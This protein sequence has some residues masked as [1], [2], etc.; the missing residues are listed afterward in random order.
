MDRFGGGLMNET[1]QLPSPVKKR[2]NNRMET[3][4]SVRHAVRNILE[5]TPAFQEASP[6]LKKDIAE[7]M[8][9]VSM[10][11]ADMIDED[12]QLTNEIKRRQQ[13]MAYSLAAG[14]ILGMQATRASGRT[15]QDI[16]EGIDFPG[17]VTD[18][19]NGVFRAIS[20]SN[21]QQLQS[22]GDL[23]TNVTASSSSFASRNITVSDA[24][25]WA[26]QNFHFLEP[27]EEDG[28]PSLQVKKDTD[29]SE[30]TNLLKEA[31][32]ATES[33]IRN[34]DEG[35][36]MSTLI[37]LIR[38]KM[39]RDRQT[40]LSTMIMM[41][42]QRVVVDQGRMHASMDLR[43]DTRSAAEEREQERKDFRFETSASGKF[44]IGAWGASAK[45]KTSVGIVK[46]TDQL[47]Q[48]EIATRAGLRSSVDL[49]FH[50]E[51]VQ[52]ER[53]AKKESIATVRSRTLN[54]KSWAPEAVN[55]SSGDKL[56]APSPRTT[57][58]QL[59]AVPPLPKAPKAETGREREARD[60]SKKK[61]APNKDKPKGTKPGGTKPK[62]AKPGDTKPKGAQPK[63]TKP[64]G[65]KT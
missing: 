2:P 17:F 14:D 40:I 32:D 35:D 9:S 48:E 23:L 65:T 44:G 21:L 18:L 25:V 5:K 26:L 59:P 33:E 6:T 24:A 52:L 16:R 47:T 34:I 3:L 39:G 49:L 58:K 8:V 46:N 54:P 19:I 51:P 31:L 11:A 36:L 30:H 27:T 37:P 4:N 42:L 57:K 20:T 55:V 64:K 61:E 38:R 43:V 41:G 53:I 29:L 15:I 13:P 63:G 10:M 1:I 50:S 7:K 12:M 28:Q 62:E 60:K 45:M 22:F 56:T